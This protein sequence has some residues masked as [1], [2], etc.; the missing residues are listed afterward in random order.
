MKRIASLTILFSSLIEFVMERAS[1]DLWMLAVA[2][3]G[4]LWNL[5]GQ[6]LRSR[7]SLQKRDHN[8]VS[9]R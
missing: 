6:A 2:I 3:V 9:K 5:V 4:L 8:L 1:F 7:V